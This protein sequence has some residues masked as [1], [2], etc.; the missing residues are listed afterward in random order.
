LRKGGLDKKDNN[1][2]KDEFGKGNHDRRK[3]VE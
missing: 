3:L 1:A 2:R